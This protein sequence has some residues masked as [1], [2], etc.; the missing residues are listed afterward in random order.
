[1]TTQ[2]SGDEVSVAQPVPA[3]LAEVERLRRIEAAARAVVLATIPF[4]S[5]WEITCG[6]DGEHLHH[7]LR[8]ALG[9]SEAEWLA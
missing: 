7:E 6:T 5:A 1:V 2:P 9:I 4:D 8:E 3:L